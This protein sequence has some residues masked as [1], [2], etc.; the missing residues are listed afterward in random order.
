MPCQYV[1]SQLPPFV[2]RTTFKKRLPHNKIDS[3]LPHIFETETSPNGKR[4]EKPRVL[5]SF[6][7]SLSLF[8]MGLRIKIPFTSHTVESLIDAVL[9]QKNDA[10]GRWLKLI[11]HVT[12]VAHVVALVLWIVLW[13]RQKPPRVR[14]KVDLSKES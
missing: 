9:V 5:F 2:R 8:F 3:H 6:V 1:L 12:I 11:L 7:L 13:A 14:D 10:L 4:E